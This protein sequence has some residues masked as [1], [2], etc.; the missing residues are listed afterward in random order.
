MHGIGR[1]LNSLYF[2]IIG[3]VTSHLPPLSVGRSVGE[4]IIS[5]K[6]SG[7]VSLYMHLQVVLSFLQKL[8]IFRCEASLQPITERFPHSVLGQHLLI[9]WSSSKRFFSSRLL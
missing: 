5:K 9:K 2:I 8:R 6:G 7:K 4:V 1:L 3:S